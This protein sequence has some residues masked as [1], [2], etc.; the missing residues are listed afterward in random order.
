MPTDRFKHSHH[1]PEVIG[2]SSAIWWHCCQNKLPI[3][4]LAGWDTW[5]DQFMICANTTRSNWKLLAASLQ[6]LFGVQAVS[7]RDK[8]IA[9][10][11]TITILVMMMLVSKYG[12][13]CIASCCDCFATGS[14]NLIL[15][16]S[17]KWTLNAGKYKM[18]THDVASLLKGA[19]CFKR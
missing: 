10:N 17:L 18:L 1:N 14:S 12:C 5:L 7:K 4:L 6:L 8:W 9:V 11:V 15:Y 3:G 16:G 19:H 2:I 13:S